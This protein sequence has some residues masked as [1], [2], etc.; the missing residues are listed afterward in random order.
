MQR[1][2][3]LLNTAAFL[4]ACGASSHLRTG[5]ENPYNLEVKLGTVII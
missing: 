5:N 2:A 3:Q 1:L 4:T